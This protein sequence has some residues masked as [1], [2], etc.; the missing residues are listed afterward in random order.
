M[1]FLKCRGNVQVEEMSEGYV[2]PEEVE[3]LEIFK[4]NSHNLVHVFAHSLH[5]K[6]C[7]DSLGIFNLCFDRGFCEFCNHQHA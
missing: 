1:T 6:S 7:I 5:F 4:Y 3:N 2:P